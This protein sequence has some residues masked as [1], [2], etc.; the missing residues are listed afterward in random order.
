MQMPMPTNLKTKGIK[1]PL[2]EFAMLREAGSGIVLTMSRYMTILFSLMKGRMISF[3]REAPKS[4][5]TGVAPH[6]DLKWI[7]LGC[8]KIIAKKYAEVECFWG[9]VVRLKDSQLYNDELTNQE[10]KLWRHF[11][12][13]DSH[14]FVSDSLEIN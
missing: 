8:N 3:S 12:G 13:F 9:H 14:L 5:R 6:F 1:K 10:I 4:D 7:G 11:E 2:K